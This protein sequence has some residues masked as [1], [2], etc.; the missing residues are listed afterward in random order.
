[1]EQSSETA[2]QALAFIEQSRVK[3]AAATETPPLRHAAFAALMGVLV[4]SPAVPVPF[5]FLVLVAIFAA[6]AWIVR[7]DRRRMG[8]FVNGYRAGKTRWVSGALLVA[9][10]P[11]YLIATWLTLDL[12]IWWAALPLGLVAAAMAYGGSVWWCRVFRREL[13]GT[14]A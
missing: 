9:V 13:L 2:A 3:L 7:W 12:A 6:A 14:V 10:L 11:L 8:L 1:M 5:R 4:A